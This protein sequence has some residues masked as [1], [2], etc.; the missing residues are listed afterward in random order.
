M[1]GT[2]VTSPKELAS[3]CWQPQPGPQYALI[4][5]PVPDILFGGARGGGKTAACIGKWIRH[6]QKY[7]TAARG[8]FFR[9]TMPELEEVQRQMTVIL[10]KLGAQYK[11]QPRIWQMPN[12]AQIKLR[13]LERDRDADH[14]QG[15]QYSIQLWDELGNWADPKPVDELRASLRSAEGVPCQF[16]ATANPGGIGHE[17]IQKRYVNPSPSGKPFF[18]ESAQIWRVFI[19]SKLKDNPALLHNDPDYVNRLKAATV[20]QPHLLRAWLE[21][22]WNAT[23]EG[24]MIK[25][26]WFG[27]YNVPPVNYT[28]IVQSWD[29]A[30]KAKELNAPWV[31]GTWLEFDSNYYLIDVFRK[32]MLYPEGKRMVKSLA[33]KYNPSA[34]LIEDK[35]TGQALIPELREDPDFGYSVIPVEPCGDKE[36]RMS[37]ESPC[38][39]SGRVWLPHSAPWLPEFELEVGIFPLSATKDQVDMMSQFL[40]WIR[41]RSG[42]SWLSVYAL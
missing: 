14:Y 36:T 6:A 16:I 2:M 38:I 4:Q 5:C 26:D 31:G 19:P 23:P 17:W 9:R 7:G 27:R 13:Y 33:A 22:D 1:V 3:I 11:S 10:P 34:I 15:H 12:D 24:G 20:G 25:L 32:Q 35:S 41:E 21:G 40:K 37:T 8:I 30:A 42:E 39:E 28:R 29:T 18:D